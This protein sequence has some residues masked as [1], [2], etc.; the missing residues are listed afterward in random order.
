MKRKLLQR[1][2]ILSL[3]LSLVCPFVNFHTAKLITR[4]GDTQEGQVQENPDSDGETGQNGSDSGTDSSDDVGEDNESQTGGGVGEGTGG[5]QTGG[6]TRGDLDQ[7]GEGQPQKKLNEYTEGELRE[8]LKW[9]GKT[10]EEIEDTCKEKIRRK[11][12]AKHWEAPRKILQ[13]W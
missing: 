2:G 13:R 9:I 8:A 7:S 11:S 10:D 6:D 12:L 1:I 4:A 5:E 3:A